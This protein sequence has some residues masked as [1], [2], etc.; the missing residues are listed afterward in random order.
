[1]SP[2]GTTSQRHEEHLIVGGQSDDNS[3]PSDETE[4]SYRLLGVVLAEETKALPEHEE[5]SDEDEEDYAADFISQM[6][7]TPSP[8]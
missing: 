4:Q 2:T 3:G 6:I 1:M 5:D 7:E 8:S